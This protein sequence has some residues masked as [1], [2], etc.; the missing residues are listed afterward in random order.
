MLRW[1]RD[2]ADFLLELTDLALPGERLSHDELVSCCF[3]D[4]DQSVVLA[5]DGGEAAVAVVVRGSKAYL[6]LLAVEPKAQG[7]GLG[8]TMLAAAE[9][10]AFDEAGATSI[11]A[12]AAAPFY[13]WPGVDVHWTRALVLLEAAGWGHH[14]AVMN[15]SCPTTVRVPVPAGVTVRRALDDADV[16]AARELCRRHWT[17][18]DAEVERGAEHGA[19]FVAFAAGG[20]GDGGGVGEAERGGGDSDGEGACIGFAC[21]SVNRV[22][23][24]GPMATDP[25][26]RHRGVGGA[27]LGALLADLRAH[28]L[29][30]A[31]ISWV[32]P[33]GFYA[34]VA[35]ASV[36]RVFRTTGRIR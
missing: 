2:D 5:S 35:G 3:D 7:T 18:W 1:T 19:C 8:R 25:S 22:G 32:G 14:G 9:E 34:R 30:D 13:L 20:G 4:D 23:W 15:M 33:I 16:A 12:G 27:M 24:I 17:G 36:S 29:P 26:T 28:S 11:W 21:H 6:Q 10:W 31:Q